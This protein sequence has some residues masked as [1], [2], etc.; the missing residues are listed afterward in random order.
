M[1]E[2]LPVHEVSFDYH[3]QRDGCKE[4]ITID[5]ADAVRYP[6]LYERLMTELRREGW[7]LVMGEYIVC[8]QRCAALFQGAPDEA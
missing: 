7:R 3:C 4:R 6:F 1:V 2:V 5:I 8:S